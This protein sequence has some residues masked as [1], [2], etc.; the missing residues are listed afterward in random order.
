[1]D[2][3][4]EYEGDLIVEGNILGKNGKRYDLKVNGNI[5]AG[6]IIARDIDAWNI[7]ASNITANDITAGDIHAGN[8]TAVD[9][10]A[11]D[12]S[13]RDITYYAVCFAYYDI[14]CKSIIGTRN[15]ARHFVLDGKIEVVK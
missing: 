11:L 6:N 8:I 10:N 14:K 12:I 15:N 9:I 2:K 7:T 1:M 13:A 4:M 3:D 5:T